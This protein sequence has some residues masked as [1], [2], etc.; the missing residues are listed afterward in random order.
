MKRAFLA[1]GLALMAASCASAPPAP[2]PTSSVSTGT[3]RFNYD[4]ATGTASAMQAEAAGG[5]SVAVTCQAPSGDMIIADYRLA[6]ANAAQ[7]DVTIRQETIRVPASAG[8]GPN[9]RPA[10]L[11]RLPRRPPNL[12]A[13]PSSDGTVRLAA[14]SA[15]HTYA[16]GS[17]EKFWQVAQAC[18]PSGS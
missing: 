4:S 12:G 3:W 6:G 16:S 13:Y 5:D 11:V 8:N 10:L 14:G 15:T 7:V 2:T 1:L 9:G 18:W 17:I